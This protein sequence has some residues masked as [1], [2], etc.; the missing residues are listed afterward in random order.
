MNIDN[1]TPLPPC[2]WRAER[3]ERPICGVPITGYVVRAAD[4]SV[5]AEQLPRGEWSAHVDET[6]ARAIAAIP[7]LVA[8][9][10]LVLGTVGPSGKC[11]INEAGLDVVRAA[12]AK[13]T[14]EDKR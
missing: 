2:P 1:A 11:H 4:G 9:C 6:L 3:F 13:A 14:G 5:V 8:A 7:D 12:V 10:R